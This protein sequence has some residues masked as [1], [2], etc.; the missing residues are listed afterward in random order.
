MLIDMTDP[1]WPRVSAAFAAQGPIPPGLTADQ[2]AQNS[3]MAFIKGVVQN[4]ESTVAL[5]PPP[6]VIAAAAAKVQTDFDSQVVRP[7]VVKG[8]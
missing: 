2:H 8:S 1:L 6:A 3:I 5:L 7:G 4:Y